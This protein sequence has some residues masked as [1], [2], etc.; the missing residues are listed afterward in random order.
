MSVR[1]MDSFKIFA[2]VICKLVICLT[3]LISVIYNLTPGDSFT[4]W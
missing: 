2:E 4:H 3:S 1:E